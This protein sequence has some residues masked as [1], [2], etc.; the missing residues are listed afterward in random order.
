MYL[1]G[2]IS[3]I[4]GVY[5]FFKLKNYLQS[6][7]TKQ[8]IPF[9]ITFS[10]SF[11]N[12]PYGDLTKSQIVKTKSSTMRVLAKDE[13]DALE[14]A[15]EIIENEIKIDIEEIIEINVTK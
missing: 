7:F 3:G 4:I 15:K 11:I 6:K 13:E 9:D 5:F 2:F 12:H 14:L 8:E 10:V 1:F